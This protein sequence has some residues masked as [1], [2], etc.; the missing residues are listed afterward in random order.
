MQ[1]CI[2]N[3]SFFAF[4]NTRLVSVIQLVRG[5]LLTALP[6]NNAKDVGMRRLW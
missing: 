1:G 4:F 3:P 6:I 2:M 5:S